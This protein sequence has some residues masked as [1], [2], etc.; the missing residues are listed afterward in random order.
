MK[1]GLL[2]AIE[3]ELEAFLKSGEERTEE[4]TAGRTVYKTRMEGHDVF[5]VCSGCG[6]IDASAATM[7]LIVKYGCEAIL[8]FGVTGALEEDLKVDDLFVVEKV[9]HYDFDAT[10]F[11]TGSVPGQYVEYPDKYIPVD[12]GL[13]KLVTDRIPG[14]RRIAAA[15][16]DKFVEDRA[17]KLRLRQAGCGIC[18][19]EIAGIART[20]ERSGV[21]CLSVKCISDTFDGNGADFAANVKKSAEK[22]FRVIR[23]V[24]KAL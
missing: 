23:E 4:T 14:I 24:L 20:C 19:M 7:L 6:E 11:Y 1:I 22:A 10:P 9:W 12:A 5:A 21:P 2:I 13:L 17:E 16:G 15:S 8:N 18:E 3:E